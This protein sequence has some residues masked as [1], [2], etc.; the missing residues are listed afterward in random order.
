MKNEQLYV[1]GA[2]IRFE[3]VKR[4]LS[5]EDIAGL[6][7]LSRRAISCIECGSND[8]KYLTLL[9]IAKAL[10]ITLCELLNAKF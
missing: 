2:K 8:P 7:G 5:Q 9:S 6:T 10:G 1:L 4:G 3:R